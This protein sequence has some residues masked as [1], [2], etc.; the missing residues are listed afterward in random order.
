MITLDTISPAPAPTLVPL[1]LVHPAPQ[2]LD[3]SRQHNNKQLALKQPPLHSR[4]VPDGKPALIHLLREIHILAGH[5]AN[6]LVEFGDLYFDGGTF[7][8]MSLVCWS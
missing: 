4:L 1:I 2:R 5:P 3:L 8:C 7:Y 6:L